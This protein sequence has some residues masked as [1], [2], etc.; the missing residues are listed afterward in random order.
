MTTSRTTKRSAQ[1]GGILSV[2]VRLSKEEVRA[3]VAVSDYYERSMGVMR[4]VIRVTASGDVRSKYRHVAEESK[5]LKRFAATT[6]QDMLATGA[7]QTDVTFTSL[8]LVAF[9]GRLLSS[10][11]VQRS[12]R[13]LK[14]QEIE[15]REIL[16]EKL[17][18]AV[19]SLR[20][21]YPQ[22]IERDLQTRRARDLQWMREKLEPSAS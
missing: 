16:A 11:S 6:L 1:T 19:Q 8:A 21:R 17:Q 2:A 18:R 9:W 10:L 20:D 14:P 5:W 12:R 7:T 4:L 22:A 15:L 3:M 13:K